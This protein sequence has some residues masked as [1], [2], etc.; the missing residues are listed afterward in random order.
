MQQTESGGRMQECCCSLVQLSLTTESGMICTDRATNSREW[1]DCWQQQPRAPLSVVSYYWYLS[2]DCSDPFCSFSHCTSPT[3]DGKTNSFT[4]VLLRKRKEP[5]MRWSSRRDLVRACTNL[6]DAFFAPDA[7]ISF[8]CLLVAPYHNLVIDIQLK[9]RQK[10]S[11]F[12]FIKHLKYASQLQSLSN[13]SWSN[14][15]KYLNI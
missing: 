4:R 7:C 1:G 9:K 3:I 2:G 5:R 15:K 13:F 8:L 12:W 11:P 6:S 14:L 10:S